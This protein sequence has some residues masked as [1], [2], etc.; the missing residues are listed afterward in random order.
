MG[1]VAVDGRARSSLEGLW[2]VGEVAAT[3]LHG[4]NRLASN[5]L[6]EAVVFATRAA[7]DIA[8]SP[9]RAGEAP[10]LAGGKACAAPGGE[11]RAALAQIRAVM[12]AQ[13]G[14]VRDE[15]SLVHA[16]TVLQAIRATQPPG[17]AQDAATAGLM[18]AV[19]ALQRRES[20]GGHYRSDWPERDPRQASRSAL[21]LAAVL[22]AAKEAS[23]GGG[24]VALAAAG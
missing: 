3:G 15:A 16:V 4:A 5:S 9:H 7:R 21:D 14:V 8:A 11:D 6:L 13:V 1:G 23:G 22:E 24:P 12:D 20:R 18:I 17:A 19:A 10:P 2:A